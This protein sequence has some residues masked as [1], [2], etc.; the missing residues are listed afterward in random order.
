M[1]LVAALTLK[2]RTHENCQWKLDVGGDKL[3]LV[4][5]KLGELQES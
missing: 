4:P 1:L 3:D 2:P 5:K